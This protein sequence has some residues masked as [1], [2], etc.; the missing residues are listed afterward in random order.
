MSLE[1]VLFDLDGTII[2][3][4]RD[5]VL[6]VVLAVRRLGRELDADERH[7][8]VGHSWNE[9]HQMIER[10]HAL[11][12]SMDELI[13]SAFEEKRAL[14][15]AKGYTPM[16]GAREAVARLA[17]RAPLAVVSGA[18]R[19]E[20]EDAID[21]LGLRSAFVFLMGAE[22]YPRG[23]PHPDPYL[24]AMRRLAVRPERT[25]VIEDAEPGIISG[26]AAGARVAAVRAGNFSGYD[27]G[28][29]H[30]VVDTLEE[31]TDALVDSL[32]AAAAPAP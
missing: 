8:I 31:L 20:V 15:A 4:E 16:P 21:S 25:L 10:N 27:L 6:S 26:R 23:K 28:A 18:S 32:L 17:R 5:N 29:A 19:R 11:G 12:V 24:I 13:A 2:D 3:S 14:L 9:I 1:A 30:V 22:D 7:F